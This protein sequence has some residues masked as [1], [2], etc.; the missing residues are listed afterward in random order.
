MLITLQRHPHSTLKLLESYQIILNDESYLFTPLFPVVATKWHVD[1]RNN[2]ILLI[3]SLKAVSL[4]LKKRLKHG[5]DSNI[6]QAF[7]RRDV[8]GICLL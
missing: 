7:E 5:V 3:I 4:Y 8:F 1:P 2:Q 6:N